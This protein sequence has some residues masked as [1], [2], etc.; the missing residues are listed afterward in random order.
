MTLLRLLCSTL[1]CS[2]LFNCSQEDEVSNFIVGEEFTDSN[3]RVIRID[4]LSVDLSTFKLDSITTSET[5]RLL[6]GQYN[7]ASLGKISTTPYFELSSYTYS[8]SDAAVLDSVA[9]IL[10]YDQY[11]YNDTTQLMQ[12]RFHRLNE[13]VKPYDSD[14]YNTSTLSFYDSPIAT[15]TFAPRPN[16]DSLHVSIPFEFGNTMFDF[17]KDNTS[18]TEEFVQEYKGFTLQ[19]DE[20]SDGSVI[21]FSTETDSTYLR[22]FY[23][24]SD[25]DEDT[26][27]TYDLYITE[28]SDIP[29]H[30]NRIQSDVSGLPLSNLTNQDYNL[31]SLDSNNESYYQSGVGYFTRINFPS[32]RKL[33]EIEGQGT[34]IDAKLRLKPKIHS[35]ND[36]LPLKDSLS[37][38]YIDQN[39]SIT[40]QVSN[41]LGEV[42]STIVESVDGYDDVYYEIPV[43]QYIDRK[44]IQSPLIDDAI[45]LYHAD[46]NKSVDR[47]IFNDMYENEG[48]KLILTYAIY[49]TN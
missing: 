47:M 23:R 8:I 17:I 30:F 31:S 9:L 36:N 21:G 5:G 43:L 10:N 32:I 26:E 7:D 33:Y 49:D 46:Y 25:D 28:S 39:N 4:T 2:C 27:Y 6:F 48:A 11:F 16:S 22:F 35:Y 34:V 13:K 42:M 29:K 37:L 20:A 24:L 40:E 45:I 19:I 1:I 15:K 41:S 12:M 14:F 3:V 44:L 18:D 38:Y